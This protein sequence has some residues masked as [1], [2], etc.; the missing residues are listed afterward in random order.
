MEKMAEEGL[1]EEMNRHST[2]NFSGSENILYD[3]IMT[4]ICYTFVQT[5][6]MFNTKSKTQ[7]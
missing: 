2:E 3:I 7:G 6:W 5:H 1:E 4:D